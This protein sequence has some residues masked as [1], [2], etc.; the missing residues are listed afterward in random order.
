VKILT[1]SLLV[2]ASISYARFAIVEPIFNWEASD[3]AINYSAVVVLRE[4]GSIYD[5]TAL[6]QAHEAHIG[7]AGTLYQAAFLSYINPPTTALFFW[8]LSF[9]PFPAAQTIFVLLNNAAFLIA[10]GLVLYRLRA[11]P[12]VVL[13]CVVMGTHLFFYSIRQTFGLGQMNGILAAIMA[14]AL[15]ATL[16]RRDSWAGIWIVVAASVDHGDH[17]K[18]SME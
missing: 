7:P 3:L 18:V 4:G 1:I 6:R 13:I 2:A 11:S 5:S 10:M 8:P 16:D 14:A 12:L 15:I 9:L 17:W